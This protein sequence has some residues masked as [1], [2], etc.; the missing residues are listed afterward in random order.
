MAVNSSKS[1][2]LF[3]EGKTDVYH[4]AK[5]I[6]ILEMNI[7][8]DIIDMHDAGALCNFIRSTPAKLLHGKKII[9]LFDCDD[10]G[11]REFKRISGDERIMANV[12][13]LTSAQS[14][15]KSFALTLQPPS[16]LEEYCP[17]EFLYQFEHLK[18]HEMLEKRNYNQ[19]KEIF[20]GKSPEEDKAI[21]NEYENETSLR[22]FKVLDCKKNEFS[23]S[24]K[25][26]TD[27]NLFANFE[28]TLKLIKRIVDL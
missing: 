21:A 27:R 20:K 7:D 12:K 9:A 4:L 24:I 19:Y 1:N 2:V 15:G 25:K 6:E 11:K 5:A 8:I 3:V 28:L 16:G 18:S 22:P 26:E 23:E 13:R 17:I 10:E 14:E